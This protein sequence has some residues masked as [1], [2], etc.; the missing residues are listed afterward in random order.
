MTSELREQL[1]QSLD[2]A[3]WNWLLP[4]VKRDAAI[5]VSSELDLLD[6]G[7]AIANNDTTRVQHWIETQ[8]IQKPSASQLSDWN[9]TPSKRFNAIIVQPFVVIQAISTLPERESSEC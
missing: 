4:H 5:V 1:A 2:E 6:V 7:V 9:E 3:Q 8:G